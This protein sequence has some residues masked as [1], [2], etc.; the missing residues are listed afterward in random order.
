MTKSPSA[1]RGTRPSAVAARWA[2]LVL[3]A[4]LVLAA[5]SSAAGSGSTHQVKTSRSATSAPARAVSPRP[6]TADVAFA[7]SLLALD[8][9]VIGPGFER[10]TGYGYTG[11]GG[12]S[13]GL[14]HEIAAGEIAPDVFE[15]VGASPISVLEPRFATW[16]VQLASSPLVI[17]YN[18]RS[19]YAST[20]RSVASG[21]APLSDA[22]EAMASKGFLLGRTNPATDPQG[23]AFVMMMEL[24]QSYLHLPAGTVE[25][26]LGTGIV[27][28][29]GGNESQ[30]FSETSLDA[31]LEAGQL[32]AASAFLSQ[33]VQ[34]HLAYL[35]LPASIDLGDP[36]Y[37]SA[38]AKA[39][40]VV[41]GATPGTTT[42]VHGAPL[43][44]DATTITEPGQSAAD[45]AAAAAFVAYLASAPGRSSFAKEGFSLVPETIAGD[46][47]DV[48]RAVTQAVDGAS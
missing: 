37:A 47:R 11:R 41:P 12:G 27:S 32:D 34:L 45:R 19:P 30:I 16:S 14:A 36:A 26:I 42:T 15:S 23:Q 18:P 8:N 13:I 21:H 5:C 3:T 46:H 29:Q 17:A 6:G 43:V 24:A 48:P 20:F 44:I 25:R 1:I 22:F 33:A 9:E 31:H 40:L 28:G 35:R 7:G 38:Y 4:G 2:S 39:H 10:A